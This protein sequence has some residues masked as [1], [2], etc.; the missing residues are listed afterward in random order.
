[1]HQS[2]NL[3]NRTIYYDQY[4]KMKYIH[5]LNMSKLMVIMLF[6]GRSFIHMFS[7]QIYY[8]NYVHIVMVYLFC[9]KIFLWLIQTYTNWIES[10]YGVSI[11][12]IVV[13]KVILYL[14]LSYFGHANIKWYSFSMVLQCIH[15]PELF[16]I[17]QLYLQSIYSF[18]PSSIQFTF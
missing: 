6:I 2:S 13:E 8:F 1:M 9:S 18:I 16:L 4:S 7:N 12:W 14:I 11:P 17:Q 3:Q 5:D 15:L 10:F